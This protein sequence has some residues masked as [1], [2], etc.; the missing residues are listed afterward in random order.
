M[1]IQRTDLEIYCRVG[2]VHAYQGL[3]FDVLIFDVVESPGLAIAPFLREGWGSE[4]MRL[5]NVAVAAS[6]PVALY[7]LVQR[8]GYDPVNYPSLGNRVFSTAGQPVY[9]GAYL[10]MSPGLFRLASRLGQPRALSALAHKLGRAFSH[11][12]HTKEVFAVQRFVRH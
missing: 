7:A 4:S 2:T 8:A 9:L 12:L 10:A 3:E 11:L 1:A 5:L 6:L